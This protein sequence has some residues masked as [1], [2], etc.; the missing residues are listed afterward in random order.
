MSAGVSRVLT[1]KVA[2]DPGDTFLVRQAKT[3]YFVYL[4]L[5]GGR[6][7]VLG[8]A[9]R[10][11]FRSKHIYLNT[12]QTVCRNVDLVGKQTQTGFTRLESDSTHRE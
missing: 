8:G 3:N 7:R 11:I 2:S 6:M 4:L 9:D 5:P 10:P 1:L 12:R